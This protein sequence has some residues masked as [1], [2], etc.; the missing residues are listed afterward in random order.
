MAYISPKDT[1]K[2]RNELKR[3][4]PKPWKFSVQTINYSQVRVIILEGPVDFSDIAPKGRIYIN[5][6]H[7]HRYGR[8]ESLLTKIMNIIKYSGKQWYD[9]S[10][11][12]IDYFDVAF[13]I[14]LSIG[15]YLRPYKYIVPK[16][17]DAL[18]EIK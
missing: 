18:G 10:N 11:S 3:Q 8:H 1:A 7:L 2:I 15:D 6:F 4:F 13:Y 17:P 14:S 9:N 12:Q 5:E 16:I